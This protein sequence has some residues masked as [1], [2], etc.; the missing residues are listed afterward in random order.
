MT[1]APPPAAPPV[2]GPVDRVPAP[3]L[4]AVSIGSVQ[5]GSAVASTLF[6]AL[7]APGTVLLRLLLAGGLLA[8][9]LRPRV[10]RWSAGALAGCALLGAAMA[11]MN[12]LFYLSIERLPLGVAVSVELLGP[13][14][15][16][17]V[18][19]RRAQDALWSALALA[20]VVLL[21]VRALGDAG[22]GEGLDV[23]GLVLAA[24]AGACWAGYILASARV[25]R[26]VPGTGGLAVSLLVGAVLV[27]PF[28]LGG[29]L[30]VVERPGLLLAALAVALLSS[31]VPYGADLAALR[32]LPTRVF[33]VLMS[34][35][36]VAAAIAGLVVLGQGLAPA[37]LVALALVSTASAGVALGRR[38]G[39]PVQA[40]PEDV[41]R[42]TG[43]TRRRPRLR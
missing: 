33:G 22:A 8:V 25:G 26:L 19:A 37:E 29:A 16:S 15:L 3:L 30:G 6:P 20:G 31:V 17:V 4:M 9:L 40:R 11:G 23:L 32:R 41:S 5:F 2:L 13:L 18:Q 35:Q 7:G 34:L 1:A 24:S 36:P 10:H 38:R 12:A 21:G 43:R 28:G 27:A 14:V 42:T 39:E